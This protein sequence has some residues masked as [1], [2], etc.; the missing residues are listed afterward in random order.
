M[1]PVK[2]RQFEFAIGNLSSEMVDSIFFSLRETGPKG[3]DPVLIL[4]KHL[5]GQPWQ[6][7]NLAH[8]A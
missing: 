2:R 1:F 4:C 5:L 7:S 3:F 8:P 6:Y